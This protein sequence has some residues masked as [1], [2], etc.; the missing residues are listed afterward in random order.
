MAEHNRTGSEG[1]QIACLF[2]EQQGFQI[3]HRNWRSGRD[4]V[5][6]VA[7]T[8][9]ELIFVEVKT[10]SSD[11][12]GTPDE[13]VTVAKQRRVMRAADA[14]LHRHSSEL[15]VRYDVVSIVMHP[16]GPHIDHI[17]DAFHPTPDGP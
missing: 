6:I 7:R 10:R 3:L 4:E 2:L 11:R 13:A 1:E 5:D 14:Y 12:F 9:R 17:I 15:D 8:E 16:T